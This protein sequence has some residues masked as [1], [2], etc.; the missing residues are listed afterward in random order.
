MP[1]FRRC[2]RKHRCDGGIECYCL[3]AD[4][5]SFRPDDIMAVGRVRTHAIAMLHSVDICNPD[6]F[7]VMVPATPDEG[8]RH[9][10]GPFDCGL[11]RAD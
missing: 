7:A 10:P 4:F 8:R 11:D 1:Q 3:V 9:R 6:P 5:L 2:S